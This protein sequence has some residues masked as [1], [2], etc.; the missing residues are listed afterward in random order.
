VAGGAGAGVVSGQRPAAAR[1]ELDEAQRLGLRRQARK[2][3]HFFETH[4]TEAEN[5]LP[6]DNLQEVPT[7]VIAHRTSPTNI[8][9]GLLANLARTTS[10]TSGSAACSRAAAPPSARWEQLERYR[11]HFLNWYDTLSLQ[12]L[13]P[14]YVSAVDSGNL[15]GHLLVLRAGLLAG[16]RAARASAH[17]TRPARHARAGAARAWAGGLAATA[18]ALREELGTAPADAGAA[19]SLLQRAARAGAGAAR[20][21]ARRRAREAQAWALSLRDAVR[22]AAAGSGVA[23][24]LAWPDR[25]SGKRAGEPA[26]A[27]GARPASLPSA[28]AS[29]WRRRCAE[30]RRR[31][32]PSWRRWRSRRASS[33]AC[34]T[35]SCTTRSGTCWRSATTSTTAAS[36][37]ASTT[38]SPR[39]RAWRASSRSRRDSCRRKAGSRS[40]ACSPPP[41]PASRCCCRGAARCSST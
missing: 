18:A 28:N 7:P 20:V 40:A 37:P 41:A 14:R 13:P 8:G 24:A 34:N 38:C 35:A 23:A 31:L 19:Q 33:R 30:A 4:V 15:A 16:G 9:L 5:W 25:G 6:P 27:R 32:A 21:G 26:R 17:R 22:F 11:G 1:R 39:R 2:T 12:P 29:R 10:V 3:W 36:T